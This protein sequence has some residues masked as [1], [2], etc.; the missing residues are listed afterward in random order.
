MC[1]ISAAILGLSVPR[2]ERAWIM[3]DRS[4]SRGVLTCVFRTVFHSL[5]SCSSTNVKMG[6]VCVCLAVDSD[7]GRRN[8]KRRI[9]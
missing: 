4:S 2:A 5:T 7:Q 6:S 8:D 1:Q 9:A 3:I